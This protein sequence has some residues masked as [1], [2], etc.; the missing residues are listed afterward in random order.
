MTGFHELYEAYSRDVYRFALYLSNDPAMADDITSETFVR[1]WSSPEPVRLA[2]VKGY[3]LTIA[4]NLW[5]MERRRHSRRG[6]LVEVNDELPDSAPSVSRGV[7]VK[8]E[9]GRVLRALQEFPEADRA[10]LLMRAIEGMSYEEIA[11]A[12]GLP[13]ATVKV[14]VHRA[15]LRLAQMCSQG[16]TAK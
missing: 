9:L 14:K 13:V 4:R 3:L 7:E 1:A 5:L 16:I 2:T 10:A 15:R 6:S 11:A 8:D 12:L